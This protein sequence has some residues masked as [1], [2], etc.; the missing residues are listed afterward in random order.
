MGTYD[1]QIKGINL[2]SCSI[3][4]YLGKLVVCEEASK[5]PANIHRANSRHSETWLC[6]ISICSSDRN[7]DAESRTKDLCMLESLPT[8]RDFRVPRIHCG[9]PFQYL[10]R[11][12][13]RRD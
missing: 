2:Y 7:K 8:L 3:E 4:Q 6:Y 11:Q 10:E 9:I 12:P 13:T 5:E 1:T